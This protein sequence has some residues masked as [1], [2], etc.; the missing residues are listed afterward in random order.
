M[1]A[2]GNT[3]WGGPALEIT[4]LQELYDAAVEARDWHTFVHRVAAIL[5]KAG[6]V[7]ASRTL[8][9]N[10]IAPLQAAG[11]AGGDGEGEGL[12]R[13]HAS[14]A[15]VVTW[16]PV[17]AGDPGSGRAIAVLGCFL[18]RDR[19][20]TI[21]IGL[22]SIVPAP[23]VERER[24]GV[25]EAAAVLLRVFGVHRRV[26]Q[27]RFLNRVHHEVLN[28]LPFGI[29]VVDAEARV[30][31]RNARA[32]ALIGRRDGLL[33]LKGKLA[34]AAPAENQRL[35]QAL[36]AASTSDAFEVPQGALCVTRRQ[37]NLPLSVLVLPLRAS[38]SNLGPQPPAASVV[39]IGDPESPYDLS[40]EVIGRF[41]GL[42]SAESRVLVDLV[43]GASLG[44]I[45]EGRDL[46]RNTIKTQLNQIFRKTQTN[47]QADLVKV[48][49][50]SPA[51]VVG[52]RQAGEEG[53]FSEPASDDALDFGMTAL[54]G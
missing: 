34:A 2:G 54:G 4:A 26:C 33:V 36:A 9:K 16:K 48:V 21:L 10:L 39:V 3:T 28:K 40:E 32:N 43:N 53:D 52:L 50:S 7:L 31:T 23:A 24:A 1:M 17:D 12:Y 45:A 11:A 29:L 41:F 14:D 49:L 8:E 30:L 15:A 13:V 44:E 6:F 18:A 42:T 46:T 27:T 37:V 35:L 19:D 20:R 22:R 51:I 5:R 25:Q 38:V 47:R